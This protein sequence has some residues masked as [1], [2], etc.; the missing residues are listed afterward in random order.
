MEI[1]SDIFSVTMALL[2]NTQVHV[3][4]QHFKKRKLPVRYLHPLS[5]PGGHKF[6]GRKKKLEHQHILQ[7][8]SKVSPYTL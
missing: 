3:K 8:I 1:K 6:V 2:R 5:L 4:V 7:A